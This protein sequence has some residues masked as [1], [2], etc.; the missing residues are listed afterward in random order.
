MNFFS[1]CTKDISSTLPFKVS[2]LSNKN[3][4]L[5]LYKAEIVGNCWKVYSAKGCI[6]TDYFY[7]VEN[8]DNHSIFS[9]EMM[10]G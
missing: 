9:M 8:L 10:K 7:Y 1:T 2:K 3:D 4:G 6:E 5:E